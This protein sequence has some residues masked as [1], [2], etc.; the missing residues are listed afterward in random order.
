MSDTN[1]RL[2][3]AWRELLAKLERV[4]GK[5][6]ADEAETRKAMFTCGYYRGATDEL[7]ATNAVLSELRTTYLKANEELIALRARYESLLDR[8]VDAR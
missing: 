4:T 8:V 3:F 5:L 7:H 1:D 2:Q 6:P